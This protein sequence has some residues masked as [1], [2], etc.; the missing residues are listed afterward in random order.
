MFQVKVFFFF[1]YC[2]D[3]STIKERIKVISL[4][5]LIIILLFLWLSAPLAEWEKDPRL[6]CQCFLLIHHGVWEG[7]SGSGEREVQAEYTEV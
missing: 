6:H 3:A 7:A 1:F 4:L 2:L 5:S